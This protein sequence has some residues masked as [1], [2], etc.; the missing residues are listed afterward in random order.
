MSNNPVLVKYLL[1]VEGAILKQK[2]SLSFLMPNGICMN[3]AKSSIYYFGYSGN[4]GTC[5]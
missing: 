3:S 4:I 1:W 2:L 5:L